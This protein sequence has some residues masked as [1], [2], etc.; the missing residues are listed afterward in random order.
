M[1]KRGADLAIWILACGLITPAA[2]AQSYGSEDQVLTVGA[3]AFRSLDSLDTNIDAGGY[4]RYNGEPVHLAPLPLPEGALIEGLCLY[5]DDSDSDPSKFVRSHVV[6]IK[7]VPGGES[8]ALKIVGPDVESEDIGYHD[9]C[10]FYPT[11]TL[12]GRIDVDGD[13]APDPVAYYV[14]LEVPSSQSSLGAGGVV[15]TW[16]RQ[17]S[18]PP[19]S[20]PTFGDVPSSDPG[21]GYIEALAASGITAGCAGG[22]YCPDANLTR[23]QMGVF[24]AK[25]LGLHWAD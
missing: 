25:A 12:R 6:A 7:Q 18:A 21:F 24:L 22:N 23:R 16:R 15:I 3:A 11:V 14:H 20:S 9:V 2:T 1:K 5:A 19:P 10:D 8:P 4:L 17:V 13:G